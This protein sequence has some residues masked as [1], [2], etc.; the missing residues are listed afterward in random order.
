MADEQLLY[1][2]AGPV[3]TLTINR[4]ER[5]NAITWQML[6]DLRAALA[7]AK[8]DPEVRV[9]VLT[10]AGDKAFCAGADL[11]GMSEGAG[12]TE[13]HAGRGELALLFRDL[14]ELGKPVIARVRGY[15]LAGG[16]GL[17]LACDLVVAA[18]DAVF[19]TPE[20]DVGLWPFLITVPLLRSMP[21]KRALELMM[22]GRRVD[23]AEAERI[24]FV[25]RVV[26]VDELEE[27]VAEL[28]GTLA[29][30]SPAIMRLGRD[31][32]YSVIDQPAADA[33]KLLHP[34]LTVTTATEDAAEGMAAF[35]ERRPP[36]WKG[37]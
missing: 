31:S 7:R 14:W 16:F 29:A 3:A 24:G 30:K 36:V 2:V 27:E 21:P 9:V 15:A 28:A 8:A 34:L 18:D 20:I 22:T 25:N 12:W 23:A 35:A 33:L 37:R 1:D 10:G 26:P 5:R 4:P 13:L 32:F 17:A 6:A 19:G 11:S